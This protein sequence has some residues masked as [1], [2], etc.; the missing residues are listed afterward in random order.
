MEILVSGED[1][2]ICLEGEIFSFVSA[3]ELSFEAQ[4]VPAPLEA[5]YSF[6]SALGKSGGAAGSGASRGRRPH[7]RSEARR[8]SARLSVPRRRNTSVAVRSEER[9]VWKEWRS[10]WS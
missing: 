9:R 7:A 4:A 6:A 1:G 8:S 10:R 3:T 5:K 2:G